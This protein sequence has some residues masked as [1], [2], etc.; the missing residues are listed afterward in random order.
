[1]QRE[2]GKYGKKERVTAHVETSGK[3][4]DQEG[5][6]L[7]AGDVSD[8]CGTGLQELTLRR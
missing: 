1:M 6:A 8:R 2:R 4:E 5:R 3:A 7:L